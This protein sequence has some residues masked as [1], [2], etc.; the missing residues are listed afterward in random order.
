VIGG[1]PLGVFL[2]SSAALGVAVVALWLASL[3]LRDASIV[4]VFWGLGFV[5]VAWIA[6]A[7]GDGEP[8]RKLAVAVATSCWGLRLAGHLA[9]RNH[10]AGEDPRYA[11]MRR[12]HGERFWIVSL[13]TVFGLQ[14]ALVVLISLPIQVAQAVPGPPLGAL[15]AA[16]LTLVAV[17]LV[18]ETVADVQLARFRADPAN[19][20]RVMDRG[21]WAWSRHPNYFG[22]AVVWWGLG[23][24][25][26]AVPWG[27]ATLASPALMTFL[28]L[29]VSGVTLLERG[30]ARSKPGWQEYV[31]RTSAFVPRPPRPRRSDR[32]AG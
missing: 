22:D 28:L 30:L 18:F 15:D 29:R 19:R 5:G 8:G 32:G 20:G 16:G 9:W 10:G 7:L 14:G 3:A 17:G 4:D 6:F 26:C 2:A 25:A 11:R 12:H 24:L 27:F 31:E 13:A 23:L 21:L 1:D